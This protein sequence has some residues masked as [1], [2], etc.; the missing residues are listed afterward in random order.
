MAGCSFAEQTYLLQ[1]AHVINLGIPGYPEYN[2]FAVFDGHGGTHTSKYSAEHVLN[3]VISQPD[4]SKDHKN[5]DNIKRAY[6]QGF[7]ETDVA[8]RQVRSLCSCAVFD[9]CIR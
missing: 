3:K 5:L 6:T 9:D 4:W 7:L 1:D 8:L 2:W